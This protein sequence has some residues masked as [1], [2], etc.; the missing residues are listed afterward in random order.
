MQQDRASAIVAV[1]NTA[2]ELAAAL[3]RAEE[4]GVSLELQ[5]ERLTLNDKTAV[6]ISLTVRD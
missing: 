6:F 4:L 1:K 5:V 2:D 3:T